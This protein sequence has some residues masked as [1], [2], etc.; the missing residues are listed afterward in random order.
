MTAREEAIAE[1]EKSIEHDDALLALIRDGAILSGRQ[2]VAM[3]QFHH[4][5]EEA[6]ADPEVTSAL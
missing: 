1:L 3:V 4:M 2:Y 6:V 5:A